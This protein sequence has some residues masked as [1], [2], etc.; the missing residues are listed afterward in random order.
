MIG[1]AMEFLRRNLDAYLAE[2]DKPGDSDA[3][4]LGNIA[5]LADP[6]NGNGGVA[7]GNHTEKIIMS[8]VN[9]QEEF[10]HKNESPYVLKGDLTQEKRN[11][12][13]YL[14]L[15]VLFSANHSNYFFALEKLSEVVA[16]FQGKRHFTFRDAPVPEET[17]PGTAF[18]LDAQTKRKIDLKLDLHT[19]NFEQINHLW[20]SLG[21]KQVPFVL[22]KVRMVEIE[23]Q[24]TL[25]GG[26]LIQE[27]VVT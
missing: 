18:I 7:E 13:V 17:K 23:E 11:P 1:K 24:R 22:Y 20:G 6:A 14:N 19:L 16:F 4:S 9:I 12:P 10:V 2:D 27:I 3:I 8:L 26:G 5:L 15:Y 25:E 21:G